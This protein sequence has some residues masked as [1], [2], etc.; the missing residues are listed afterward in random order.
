MLGWNFLKKFIL[1]SKRESD[2]GLCRLWSVDY[3]DYVPLV[4][5]IKSIDGLLKMSIYFS[6]A[7]NLTSA[8]IIHSQLFEII[9]PKIIWYRVQS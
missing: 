7:N 5:F 4:Y 6:T 2:W 8:Q 3:V 9:L 1:L